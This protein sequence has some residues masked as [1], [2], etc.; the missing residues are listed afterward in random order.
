MHPDWQ[1]EITEYCDEHSSEE[2]DLLRELTAWTWKN[3]VNPRML[4][5]KL[6]GSLLAMFSRML[7]PNCILELGTFTGYSALCLLEGL[8]EN[9][10]LYSIEADAENAWKAGRFAEKHPRAKQVEIKVGEALAILPRL[11]LKPQ[12]IFVDADKANYSAYLNLCFAMLEKGGVL[13]FD[14]TLWSGRVLNAEDRENDA[15]TAAMHRFNEETKN[16][17]GATVLMLPFRDGLTLIFKNKD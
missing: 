15:D 5:G 13:I 6:Q 1:N 8:S 2:A 12:L 3:T 4:S 10:T 16:L 9:G 17:Q 7:R 14:N 11:E